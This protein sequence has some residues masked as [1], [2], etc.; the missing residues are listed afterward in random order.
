MFGDRCILIRRRDG[1]RVVN[2]PSPMASRIALTLSRTNFLSGLF[3]DGVSVEMLNFVRGAAKKLLR[4]D[5]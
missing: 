2:K 1:E 3:V 5:K 4:M